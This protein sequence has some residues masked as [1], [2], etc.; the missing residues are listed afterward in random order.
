MKKWA[1]ILLASVIGSQLVLIAGVLAGCFL[2]Y[3]KMPNRDPGDER[4]SGNK[5][6]ELL[7]MTLA[8]AFALYAAEK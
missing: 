1:F 6:G 5:M 4:C 7:S 3:P 2:V 8:N